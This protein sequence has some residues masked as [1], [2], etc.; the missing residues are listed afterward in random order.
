MVITGHDFIN[1][2]YHQKWEDVVTL[3]KH[4]EWYITHWEAW[5]LKSKYAEEDCHLDVLERHAKALSLSS[6]DKSMVL[7]KFNAVVKH[8][9]IIKYVDGEDEII[10]E[11]LAA[12]LAYRSWSQHKTKSAQMYLL[13][14][15]V[16]DKI[17][18]LERE[19]KLLG[20]E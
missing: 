4:C 14:K 15:D 10:R 3:K 11:M 6:E 13:Y 20:G 1:A 9:K 12:W 2:P 18:I 8:D 5:W 19:R 17:K 16:L 7:R